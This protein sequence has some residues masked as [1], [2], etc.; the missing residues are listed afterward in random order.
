MSAPAKK[1]KQNKQK[2]RAVYPD[3]E[4]QE[5]EREYI[6]EEFNH[7]RIARM[8]NFSL[9]LSEISSL[10]DKYMHIKIFTHVARSRRH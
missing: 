5:R 2:K 8:N 3:T 7:V 1:T 10:A 4:I 9:V 6:S